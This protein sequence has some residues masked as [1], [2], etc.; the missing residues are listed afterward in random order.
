MQRSHGDGVRRTAEAWARERQG[1]SAARTCLALAPRAKTEDDPATPAW[2]QRQHS[3]AV[4]GTKVL[5]LRAPGVEAEDPPQQFRVAGFQLPDAFDLGP[6]HSPTDQC[7]EGVLD[8]IGGERQA[9][10][11]GNQSIW[12]RRK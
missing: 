10:T 12:G 6:E 8:L 5:V 11:I 2:R 1:P 9:Q 7:I 3:T 4:M